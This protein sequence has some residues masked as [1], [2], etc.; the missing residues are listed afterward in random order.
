M[1]DKELWRA[2]API[3]EA[4]NHNLT[5]SVTTEA[6]EVFSSVLINN[7]ENFSPLDL[8][9]KGLHRESDCESP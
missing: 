3:S 5:K 9:K 7:L 4:P 1:V 8:Y 6:A 2:V